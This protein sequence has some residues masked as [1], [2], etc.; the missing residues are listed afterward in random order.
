MMFRMDPPNDKRNALHW[1]QDRAY[2]PQNE[3]G[4]HG[5][6]VTIALQDIAMETGAVV[7]CPGSQREGFVPVVK[8]TKAD[9]ETTEQR[10]IPAHLIERY[11][12]IPAVMDK[13]DVT[14]MN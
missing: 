11:E 7:I 9:Y 13:G 8:E 14:L 3:N 6:V 5:L 4:D 1:H 2:Y 12:E 10:G